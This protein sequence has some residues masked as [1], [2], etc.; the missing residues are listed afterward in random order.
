M[1]NIFVCVCEFDL[2]FV[3]VNVDSLH[4]DVVQYGIFSC[5]TKGRDWGGAE[6]R[7]HCAWSSFRRQELE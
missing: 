5:R 4:C 3:L 7:A 2:V 1:Q 6:G